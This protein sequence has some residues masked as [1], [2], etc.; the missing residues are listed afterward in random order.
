V[1]DEERLALMALFREHMTVIEDGKTIDDYPPFKMNPLVFKYE[2]HNFL[3][4]VWL[5]GR[6][7][8]GDL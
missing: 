4:R 5:A 8:R 3:F 1:T 6:N 7:W 2:H